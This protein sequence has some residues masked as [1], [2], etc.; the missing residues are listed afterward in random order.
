MAK[1]FYYK[2]KKYKYAYHRDGSNVWIKGT[3]GGNPFHRMSTWTKLSVANMNYV[4]KHAEELLNEYWDKK[5]KKEERAKKLTV[6]ELVAPAL[7][8]SETANKG[9]K[10]KYGGIFKNHILPVFGDMIPDDITAG[11]FKKFQVDLRVKKKLGKKTID[12]IRSAFSCLM[13]Y[14]NEEEISDKNPLALVKAPAS[15]LFISYNEDG[16]AINQKGEL[17]VESVDPFTYEDT[18]VIIDAAE[19]QFKN[20]VM[21]QFFTGMRIGEMC[22]LRWGDIDFNNKTIHVQRSN[23]DSGDIGSTKNGKTRKVDMLPP[24]EKALREQFKLTGLQKQFIFLAKH[25]GRYTSYDTFSDNWKSLLIRTG[26][27]YRRFYQTRHTF[28]C[29]MLQKNEKLSWVSKIMLGHSEQ[30]TT[31]R[32]YAD[33]IPDSNERNAKFLDDYCTNNVQDENLKLGSA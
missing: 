17:I 25:G 2:N 10:K 28:A 30:S 32:F 31:L 12:N 29:I 3:V 1:I 8:V 9:T 22:T 26:Y 27:D 6:A 33:Y 24:V 16:E 23:K 7:E 13:T 5:L 11:I 20:I 18:K 14:V 15:K 4:E 19:G 21:L